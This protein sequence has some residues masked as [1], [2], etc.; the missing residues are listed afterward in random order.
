MITVMKKQK[1][2]N[3]LYNLRF[4]VLASAV[5]LS[6]IAVAWLRLQI[7]S[8]QLFYIRTEQVFGLLCILY[9]YIAIVISPLGYVVGKQRIPHLLFARRA[10]GVSAAYFAL[11]HMA[12]ALWGQL[13]GLSQLGLLPSLFKWSLLAG[14]IAVVILLIMAATSFDRVVSKMTFVRWKWLHRLVYLGGILAILHIWAVGTHLAYFGVQITAF[15]ALAALGGL[16]S[17]RLVTILANRHKELKGKD[18]FVT[19]VLV[20][21]VI[22]MALVLAIPILVNNYHS[23]HHSIAR[24]SKVI[25]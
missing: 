2:Y 21:W 19:L 22:F 24:T 13:G 17:Y 3:L 10:I 25:T 15:V 23:G 14:F 8:N 9:W 4:Y 20:I 12:V 18:Y 5:L 7:P 16:E 11:L 1:Q 6:V